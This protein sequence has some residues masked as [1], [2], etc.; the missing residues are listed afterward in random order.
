MQSFL[1]PNPGEAPDATALAPNPKAEFYEEKK[2][3]AYLSPYPEDDE[4]KEYKRW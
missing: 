4:E 1:T 2:E 3:A